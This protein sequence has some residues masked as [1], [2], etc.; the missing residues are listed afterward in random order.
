MV[1]PIKKS[2]K[3]CYAL[4]FK[5]L[6]DALTK[7]FSEITEK[8]IRTPS[9]N[10]KYD[11]Q[12]PSAV[13]LFNSHKKDGTAFGLKSA[14]EL[15]SK[16]LEQIDLKNQTLIEKID[17]NEAGFL[18]IKVNDSFAEE[19][20]NSVLRQGPAYLTETPQTIVVDFSSPNIA[21]EMHVGHMRSTIIGESICR[22]LEFMGNKVLRVNHVG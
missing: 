9:S 18:S 14:K 13:R 8:I 19:F 16:I 11:Y 20:V 17:L 10:A 21:K 1:E 5:T 3:S 6:Q 2:L 15:A 4:I 12:S 22:I 7:S